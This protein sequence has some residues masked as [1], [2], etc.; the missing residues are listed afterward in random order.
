[1]NPIGQS[2]LFGGIADLCGHD[3]LPMIRARINRR[4][5]Q[6][7]RAVVAGFRGA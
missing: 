5:E 4:F 2:L 1:M 7:E 6:G 3:A